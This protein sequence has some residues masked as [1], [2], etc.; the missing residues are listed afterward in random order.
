[1]FIK[2]TKDKFEQYGQSVTTERKLKD[3]EH[4]KHYEL[5]GH[6]DA[7]KDAFSIAIREDMSVKL[8]TDDEMSL[9]S[10]EDENFDLAAK[11]L[12]ILNSRP[13]LKKK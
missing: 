1:M 8:F 10:C 7:E 4:I 5:T 12:E 3:N 13:D 11:E 2:C 9:L 6:T